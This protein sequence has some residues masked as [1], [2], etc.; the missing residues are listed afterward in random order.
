MHVPAR[1]INSWYHPAGLGR[2]A[3]HA[4]VIA[5]LSL[6]LAG[7]ASGQALAPDWTRLQSAAAPQDR[8]ACT[9]EVAKTAFGGALAM[10]VLYVVVWE[11]WKKLKPIADFERV[12]FYGSVG[13]GAVLGGAYALRNADVCRPPR[14][15]PRHGDG[16]AL[17]QPFTSR[18]LVTKDSIDDPHRGSREA[19]GRR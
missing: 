6:P 19:P 8:R 7:A 16:R 5:V 18:A 11:T 10:A 13:V 2:A 4:C 15:Q 17:I 3:R 14:P 1:S 9:V 12:R